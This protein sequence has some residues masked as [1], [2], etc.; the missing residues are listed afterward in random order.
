M[1]IWKLENMEKSGAAPADV[2]R[3]KL[4]WRKR[5]RAVMQEL[6]RQRALRVF[7]WQ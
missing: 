4:P 3:R 1:E 5:R 6:W 2:R 7:K